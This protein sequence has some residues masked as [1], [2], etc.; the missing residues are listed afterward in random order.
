MVEDMMFSVIFACRKAS[1]HESA[2]QIVANI[3]YFLREANSGETFLM[4]FHKRSGESQVERSEGLVILSEAKDLLRPKLSGG[5][6]SLRS[7]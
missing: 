2:I 3:A 5:D 1:I 6:H 4:K 7:G